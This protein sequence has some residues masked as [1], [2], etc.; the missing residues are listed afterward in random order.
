[1]DSKAKNKGN[2]KTKIFIII[3]LALI[4]IRVALPYVVLHYTNKTLA[5]MDGYY[6][7]I[8]DIDLAI[9]RGA[10]KINDIYINKVDK[11][12]KKQTDFFSSKSID[13][14][15]E[16]KALFK[17]ALVGELIFEEPKLLFTKDKAEIGDVAKDT[18]DFKEV[19]DNFMPLR[20][21]RFEILDG[22]IHYVDN[23][24]SPKLDVAL[25]EANILATNLTNVVN[26]NTALPSTLTAK[27]KAYEGELALNMKLNALA[28]Q[29]T[30][31][32]NA[33]LKNTNLVLLNDLFTAYANV[34]VNKG[35]FG[36]YTEFAA[37][38]GNFDGYVKPI[39]KD[40]DVVGI[41]DKKDPFLQK[42]WEGTIGTV[43]VIFKNQRKDQL[44]T[45]VPIKGNFN[46]PSVKTFSAIWELLKNAFIQALMPQID[47]QINFNSVGSE[48][49]E[50]QNFFQ[51]V[52]SPKAKNK[53]KN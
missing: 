37:K 18:S 44:A 33:E 43:G 3:L 7:H 51:K 30:F 17:G 40:L 46:D 5:E 4:A 50:K 27:A 36:L 12:T 49:K 28:D 13:L 45:K 15:I 32:M 34:D 53:Q 9:Y 16:W 38:R 14:S 11:N 42:V 47:Q 25:T 31:D 39:I 22:S 21:N 8:D 23:T 10:Y 41:E 29:P 52:F 6:G 2:R 26:T 20:V 1:M 24:S 35:T 19:L 48:D